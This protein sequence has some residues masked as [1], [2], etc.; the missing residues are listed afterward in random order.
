M[1]EVESEHFLCSFSR[2]GGKAGTGRRKCRGDKHH[3]RKLAEASHKQ[4]DSRQCSVAM[5]GLSP[6]QH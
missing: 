2:K 5:Q 3:Y 6:S 1:K 4:R